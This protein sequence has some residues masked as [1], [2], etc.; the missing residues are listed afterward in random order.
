MINGE[1]PLLSQTLMSTKFL[2][3]LMSKYTFV[4]SLSCKTIGII[5][6]VNGMLSIRLDIKAE[7]KVKSN[8]PITS[9][10]D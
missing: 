9:R 3:C 6:V 4:S 8:N 2:S 5:A 1:Y 10:S 7:S